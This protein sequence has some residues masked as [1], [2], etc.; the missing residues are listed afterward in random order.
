MRLK[1]GIPLSKNVSKEE[2]EETMESELEELIVPLNLLEK[3]K[4]AVSLV[5]ANPIP[6]EH[7]V[8]CSRCRTKFTAENV[9][10]SGPCHYHWS[11]LPYD[12]KFLLLFN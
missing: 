3:N 8:D 6:H 12:S 10:S 1:K 9:L 5:A 7:V 2:S 11:K 4:F